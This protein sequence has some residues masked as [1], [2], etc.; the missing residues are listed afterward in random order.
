MEKFHRK[1]NSKFM[2]NKVMA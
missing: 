2:L 1:Q